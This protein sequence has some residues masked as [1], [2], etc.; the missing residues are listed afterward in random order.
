[1]NQWSWIGDVKF[2]FRWNGVDARWLDSIMA[3]MSYYAGI[4]GGGSRTRVLVCDGGGIRI[5]LGVGGPSNFVESGEA[6][7]EASLREA[8]AGALGD[9][10]LDAVEAAFFGMAG[11][12]NRAD[13]AEVRR[14]ARA[15]GL[16]AGCRLGVHHDIHIALRGGLV[17]DSGIALIAGT[18]SS[19][20]GRNSAGR[21]Y[22]CGGWGSLAD[23]V[24]SGGWMGRRG[25]E[26]FVRQA[27]GRL[28]ETALKERVMAFLG[29]GAV[30]DFMHRVHRIGLARQE[31]AGLARVL[32]ELEAEG[33]PVAETILREG[34]AGL[35]ELV[36]VTARELELVKVVVVLAG[37]LTEHPGYRGR[38]EGAIR[39]AVA[40]ATMREARFPPVVGA[41]LESLILGGVDIDEGILENLKASPP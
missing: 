31:L 40:G 23:D 6:V 26:A 7:A 30:E 28:P 13:Q 2:L 15:A 35:A 16:G 27:D 4:D 9:V 22:Q 5:G 25:L 41:V 14:L 19:C 33:D 18:G 38:L 1:M 32:F 21:T 12:V 24:G 34:A 36:A 20:Y 37:G 11:V 3:G 8:F 29:I 39:D 17:L 10:G